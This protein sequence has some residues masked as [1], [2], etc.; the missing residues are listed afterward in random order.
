MIYIYISITI[1]NDGI[2]TAWWFGTSFLFSVM[3]GKILPIDELIFFKMVK[4]TNQIMDHQ[5][6]YFMDLI[7]RTK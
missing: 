1:V 4:T 7:W 5:Q 3:Y 2:M 6:C